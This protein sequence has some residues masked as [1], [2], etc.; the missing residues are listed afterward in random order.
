ML[1]LAPSNQLT[2]TGSG[3]Y[4]CQKRIEGVLMRNDL[5][6]V[7]VQQNYKLKLLYYENLSTDFFKKS[8]A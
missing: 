2:V 5:M 6:A 3:Q 8:Q 7:V 1:C 4:R